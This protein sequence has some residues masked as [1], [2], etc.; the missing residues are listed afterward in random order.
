MH[1]NLISLVD[2]V[3]LLIIFFVLTTSFVRQS[4]LAIHLPEAASGEPARTEGRPPLEITVTEQGRFLVNGRAL[5]DNRAETLTAAIRNLE[6]G[7]KF[8]EAV[9]N[10]DA[11][12]MHQNVVTAMD[13]VGRMG[14]TDVHIATIAPRSE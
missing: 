12:A 6:S 2:V 1:V 10:A 11:R 7:K 14:I 8:R 9:I 5:V 13:V 3:L 4:Q